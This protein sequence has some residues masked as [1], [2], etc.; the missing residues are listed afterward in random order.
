MRI[1]VGD[2]VTTPDDENGEVINFYTNPINS[3]VVAV[4][5][6]DN[7]GFKEFAATDLKIGL[8]K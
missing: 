2:N 3:T 6:V 8:D 5:A 1:S 4:V 7:D